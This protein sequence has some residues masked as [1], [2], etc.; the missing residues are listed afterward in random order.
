MLEQCKK[1]GCSN[2]NAV[3]SPFFFLR[4]LGARS[5]RFGYVV[6][7]SLLAF[8]SPGLAQGQAGAEYRLKLA[9]LYNFAQFVQWPSDAFSDPG[10][11]LLICV[12]GQNPF[13]GE[14][15]QSLSGRNVGAH[16]IKLKHLGVN[17]DPRSCHMVFVRA[18]EL[19]AMP[20]L[21]ARSAGSSVLTV[22][23]AKG[24]AERGGIINLVKDENRL[25]FEI[26]TGAAAQTRLKISSKLLSLAKIVNN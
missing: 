11:P 21:L 5:K 12:V 13:Q 26:N 23:E 15:E 10:S 14:V 20:K 9:F 16:P 19:T 4:D 24:F 18:G 25:R 6:I 17:D 8:P 7:L 1:S 2:A 22:G 3:Y